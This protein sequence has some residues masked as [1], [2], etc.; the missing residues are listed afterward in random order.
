MRLSF[1]RKLILLFLIIIIG[2][3]AAGIAT[4]KINEAVQDTDKIVQHTREVLFESEHIVSYSQD[5]ILSSRGYVITGDSVF[6]QSFTKASKIINQHIR[7]VEVLIQDSPAQ[8]QRL[9][10]IKKLIDEKIN[11]SIL[12]IQLRK[13]AGFNEAQQLIAFGKGRQLMDEIRNLV[14]RI[15]A[16]EN[17]LL[18]NRQEAYLKSSAAFNRSFYALLSSILLLLIIVFYAIKYNVGVR[19]KAEEAL[20]LLNKEL[21]QKVEERTAELSKANEEL[22]RQDEL[23]NDTGS[24]AKVGGWEI[25]LSDMTV[26]WT[27]EVFRIHELE[28]GRMPPVEE[29]INYYAPEARP[30]IEE[31]VANAIA[32]GE[33]WNLELPFITAKG[34]HLWVRAIGK[35]EMKNGKAVRVYG[36]F[37]DITV[38]KL[39]EQ[40]INK[41]NRL[42]NFI[43]HINQMI[44]HVKDEQTLFKDTCNTAIDIG[45]FRMAWIGMVDVETKKVIPV[46][47]AGEEQGYLSKIKIISADKA[48][49]E[50]GPVGTA[51]RENKNIICNN[52]ENDPLMAPWK[53]EALSHGYRS[54]IALPIKKFG[55]NIGALILYASEPNFFDKGEVDS[56][57]EVTGDIS[58]ALE[59]FE[60]EEQRKRTEEIIHERE[61]SLSS[62]YNTTAD[63]I[64][65][66]EVEKS[67]RYLFSSVNNA[68]ERTTG[69]P[70]N[71]IIGKYVND[72]IPQPSLNLVLEKYKE[73]IEEKKIVRWEE[74]SDYPNG[75]LTGEVSVSPTFDKTGNCIRLV[76]AVH[77]ITER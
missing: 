46:M 48:P 54:C 62:I 73:A 52:I 45:K 55:N 19:I 33:G 35:A 25:N 71:A 74:T 18:K 72:I 13:N 40:K 9:D 12:T 4:Y 8:Q 10:S 42:Y 75:R 70:H 32:T 49:L 11:F 69:I 57:D 23:L 28:P 67:E 1:E 24:L 44:V 17:L 65:V 2:I 53:T 36:V 14:D 39:A 38:R 47:H 76:G 26:R 30:V 15:Q 64:F 37:Q 27:N 16:D 50:K 61:Q 56:L 77:D 5:F 63:I 31:A 21:E 51:I 6:L 22:I 59:N 7:D 34:N 60:K 29:A 3:I 41:A 66:L 43:S 20:S 58:F 68:F